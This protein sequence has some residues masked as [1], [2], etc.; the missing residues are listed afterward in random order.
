MI[1]GIKT[2]KGHWIK[3]NISAVTLIKAYT[4]TISEGPRCLPISAEIFR[5]RECSSGRSFELAELDPKENIKRVYL[6]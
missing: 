4:Y 2:N 3:N 1:N 5:H 6:K